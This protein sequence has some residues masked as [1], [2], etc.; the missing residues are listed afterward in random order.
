MSAFSED[1][2]KLSVVLLT[3]GSLCIVIYFLG[4]LFKK[5][6]SSLGISDAIA[7]VF[8]L[9]CW[10]ALHA[11]RIFREGRRDEIQKLF[12]ATDSSQNINNSK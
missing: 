9:C 11:W 2:T 3:I 8:I 4:L 12:V 6:Q 1:R 5:I 7:G 10:L